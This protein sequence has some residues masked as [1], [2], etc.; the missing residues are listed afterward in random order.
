MP[1][2]C[3]KLCFRTVQKSETNECA[4]TLFELYAHSCCFYL[5]KCSLHWR[6]PYQSMHCAGGRGGEGTSFSLPSPYSDSTSS[7]LHPLPPT[8]PPSQKSLFVFCFCF[9]PRYKTR[10]KD[11]RNTAFRILPKMRKNLL[12]VIKFCTEQKLVTN[13]YAITLFTPVSV[14]K[15]VIAR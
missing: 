12:L 2:C 15:S 9:Q 4:I 7:S 6:N 10:R 14:Q 11:I 1:A 8:P 13:E 3:Y 5:L